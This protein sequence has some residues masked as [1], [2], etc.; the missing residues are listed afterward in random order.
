MSQEYL[1][2]GFP[3]RSN[4]NQAVQPQKMARGLK[5]WILGAKGLFYLCIENKADQLHD[6]PEAGLCIYN[7]WPKGQQSLT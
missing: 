6:Y 2:L 1:S 5:F 7:K 3:T 4:T